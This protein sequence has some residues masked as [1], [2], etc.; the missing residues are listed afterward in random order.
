[1][2]V[3]FKDFVTQTG[4]KQKTPF[5][6]RFLSLIDFVFSARN[7]VYPAF[8]PRCT[9]LSGPFSAP[10]FAR[11]A[12][13]SRTKRAPSRVKNTTSS[14]AAAAY[15]NTINPSFPGQLFD[16]YSIARKTDAKQRGSGKI[17]A[18]IAPDAAGLL[19]LFPLS[20][21]L[22][23]AGVY[24][25]RCNPPPVF[26]SPDALIFL[27]SPFPSR[28]FPSAAVIMPDTFCIFFGCFFSGKMPQK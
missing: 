14:T 25:R 12:R 6:K 17:P 23:A 15:R 21:M 11:P 2:C 4:K 7:S 20:A 1:M 19:C 5:E 9:I 16:G 26:R 3:H 13:I 22:P 10:P 28:V 18:V 27:T 8:R 24:I